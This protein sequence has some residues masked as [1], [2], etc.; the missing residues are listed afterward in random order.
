MASLKDHYILFNR[1]ITLEVFRKI[2]DKLYSDGWK[3]HYDQ[4]PEDVY[5]NFSGDFNYL[6]PSSRSSNFSVYT[7]GNHTTAYTEISVTTFLNSF[8]DD[9][10]KPKNFS[11]N[12][13]VIC[14]KLPESSDWGVGFSAIPIVFEVGEVLIVECVT[15]TSAGQPAV[16]FKH[17]TR[18][19]PSKCFK[20]ATKSEILA[21]AEKKYPFGTEFS[22]V[23][24]GDGINNGCFDWK[25][26][27]NEYTWHPD[28]QVICCN[29]NIFSKGKW[30]PI[31]PGSVREAP[32]DKL[33]RAA[34]EY[35]P[36]TEFQSAF[37]GNTFTI[38]GTDFKFNSD[39]DVICSSTRSGPVIYC[40]KTDIWA[41]IIKAVDP[42]TKIVEAFA[43]KKPTIEEIR[44]RFPIGTKF[45][46]AHVKEEKAYYCIIVN[47][48]F[49]IGEE[50]ICALT[51]SGGTYTGPGKH[52]TTTLNR[53]VWHNGKWASIINA[54]S[55]SGM[56]DEELLAYAYKNYPE[57][58]KF[59]AIVN[60]C[61]KGMERI[62]K[63]YDGSS[64]FSWIIIHKADLGR[65]VYADRGLYNRG[66]GCS[67][68]SIYSEVT[69]WA[70]IVGASLKPKFSYCVGD[71][72]KYGSEIYRIAGLKYSTKAYILE[73]PNGW[74]AYDA[75]DWSEGKYEKGKHYYFVEESSLSLA[76]T[77]SS[78]CPLKVGDD[79]K[80]IAHNEPYGMDDIKIGDVGKI[81]SIEDKSTVR[82]TF[83]NLSYSWRA[84]MSIL[85][86]VPSPVTSFLDTFASMPY[87]SLGNIPV[88]FFDS[89]I[90]RDDDEDDYDLPDLIFVADSMELPL[91]KKAKIKP[92]KKEIVFI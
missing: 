82:V 56:S 12:D 25:I 54:D 6:E 49:K 76:P 61:D 42:R 58:T 9:T 85:Q 38:A 79:V 33:K 88:G 35:P 75:D 67:N 90:L 50:S 84:P 55:S 13:V 2:W 74:S 47:D 68:P 34:R 31:K 81:A 91:K 65:C 46:P 23:N 69:G 17:K 77:P 45:L 32:E 89:P 78:A 5:K 29:G 16:G 36:G 48:Q 20:V 63:P 62:V 10:S 59:K 27:S 86:L 22:A 53:N 44:K 14:V 73:F 71:Y 15:N 41:K 18:Y 26:K 37:S 80:V 60:S 92:I 83:P 87:V 40:A 11:V 19:F 24:S 52:G 39:Q 57:G 8:T 7:S 21:Y 1:S 64:S 66:G 28:P 4:T 43:T 30:A 70:P 3:H 51:D 72:V